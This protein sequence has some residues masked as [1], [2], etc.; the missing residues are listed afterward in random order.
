LLK[1]CLA[2]SGQSRDQTT[3]TAAPYRNVDQNV[4]TEP[5]NQTFYQRLIAAQADQCA[6]RKKGND[7]A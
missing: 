1:C 5:R 7:L 6:D 4:M 3:P 2:T